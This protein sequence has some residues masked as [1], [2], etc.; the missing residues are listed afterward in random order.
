MPLNPIDTDIAGLYATYRFYTTNLL[1]NAVISEIPLK[2]VNYQRSI[3]AAGQFSG[4][5]EVIP[6]TEHMDLYNSTMPG[7]TGLYVMRNGICVWGGIIWSRKYDI[8]SRQLDI[9]AAEFT[10]YLYHRVAWKSINHEFNG[11][12]VSDNGSCRITLTGLNEYQ[13]IKAGS[14]V[15]ILFR[16]VADFAYNGYYTVTSVLN[17]DSSVF[18][19]TIPNLPTKTYNTANIIIRSDTY[20]YVRHL[21]DSTFLDFVNTPFPNDEI[22]PS[23]G[24]DS[25]ITSISVTSNIATVT[26]ETPHT[27]VKNQTAYI[28]NVNSTFNND[29]IVT[30]V[31]N[32]YTFRFALTTANTSISY[33]SNQAT[34]AAAN[35]KQVISRSLTNYIATLTTSTSHGMAVGDTAVVTGVDNGTATVAIFGGTVT[36]S[37]V[38]APNKIEYYTAGV[39]NVA[40]GACTGTVLVTPTV[41]VGTYGSFPLNA[42]VLVDYSTTAFSGDRLE[43]IPLRGFELRSIG[44]VLNKYSDAVDGFEYRVDCEYDYE[45]G[46]F[47]RTFILLPIQLPDPPATG[48][49]SPITRFG[50]ERTIFEY[51]GNID[52]F[53][54]DESAE[55]TA[56]RFFVLGD[57][58]DLGSDSSQPY[59]AASATDLLVPSDMDNAWPLLDVVETKKDISDELELY[60]HAKR[61]LKESRPPVTKMTLSVNGSMFPQVGE[62]R[63]GDWCGVLIND[64][65]FQQRLQSPLEADRD[66]LIRK[67]ES[68]KV[69]VPNM[70]TFP[71]KVDIELIPE[72]E[73]DS[74]GE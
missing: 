57:I 42:D 18:A 19:V 11:T 41:T 29:C 4:K 52:Q 50:A 23:T 35:T 6:E 54:M 51:P 61:Y 70:P 43:S 37:G 39:Y 7:R 72:W 14:S 24:I 68:I 36:I 48:E 62:Y 26:T 30:E 10:S 74:I 17:A 9:S 59:A 27:A 32:D 15:K 46:E 55:E 56:T 16:E 28:F 22:E 12:I 13:A 66:I 40:A 60:D 64:V 58:P 20:D 44:D 69:T 33:P 67:I 38:P 25:R 65:F 45:Q 71:E 53:S 2:D 31:V 49:W 34:F 21:L 1:T 5:I 63:P 3:K 8:I 47:T 73:V